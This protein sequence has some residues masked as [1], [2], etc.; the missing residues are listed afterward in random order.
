MR[1]EQTGGSERKKVSVGNLSLV[2]NI[3]SAPILRP[4]AHSMVC[5]DTRHIYDKCET[6]WS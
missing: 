4:L 3:C 5:C 2:G 6:A 1:Y